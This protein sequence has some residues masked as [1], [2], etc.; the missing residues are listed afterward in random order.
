MLSTSVGGYG[1][2]FDVVWESVVCGP[3]LLNHSP[4]SVDVGEAKPKQNDWGGVWRVFE[5]LLGQR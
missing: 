5:L 2:G 1:Q 3:S 4:P